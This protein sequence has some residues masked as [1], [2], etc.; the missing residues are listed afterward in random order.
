[1]ETVA[2]D[3]QKILIVDDAPS[4]IKILG[5]ELKEEYRVV[6]AT[7]G[8]DALDMA[9]SDQPPQLI[10]LDVIMPRMD[11]YEVC[12][13][14][15]AD[16]RTRR[17]PVIFLTARGNDADKAKGFEIGAV[18]YITKP[19]NLAT[20]KSIVKTHMELIRH[21]DTLS[22]LSSVDKLTG[23]PNRRCFDEA[24][25]VEWHY[26]ANRRRCLSL[27]LVDI[28]FFKLYNERY[29][30]VAGD[31]CLK[32]VGQAVKE[33]IRKHVDMA[34]RSD[35]KQFAVLLP[36]ADPENAV[37]AAERIRNRIG[38]LAPPREAGPAGNHVT[39]SMG[40]A[41]L[42]PSAAVM[43]AFLAG[44][45]RKALRKAKEEGG[46]RTASVDLT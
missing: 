32:R 14:L 16:G 6:F 1:M 45:A 42:T 2:P 34:A 5:E 29:G 40:L 24:L 8:D 10:L 28:D 41:T 37:H 38:A 46:D 11:G 26:S 30:P 39:V 23:L 35:A 17:I 4:N 9:L 22:N 21:H 36:G 12:R 25:N 31:D 3:I 19:F 13:R 43:P 15:K 7:N 18:D 20:V 33:A 44:A 27:I